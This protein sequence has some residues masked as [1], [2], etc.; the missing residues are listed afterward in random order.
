MD[1]L[2]FTTGLRLASEIPS[3]GVKDEKLI[4]IV[5]HLGGTRYLSGPSVKFYNR[6]DMWRDNGIE[7]LFKSYPNYLVYDQI[8]EPNDPFVSIIDLILMQGPD[9]AGLNWSAD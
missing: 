1:Y 3:S 5:S 2:G 4:D 9:T 7:L 6:A 8:A